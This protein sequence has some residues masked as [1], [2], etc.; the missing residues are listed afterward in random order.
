MILWGMFAVIATLMTWGADGNTMTGLFLVVLIAG[1][2]AGLMRHVYEREH[3]PTFTTIVVLIAAYCPRAWEALEQGFAFPL[4]ASADS[5]ALAMLSLICFLVVAIF[6]GKLTA[7]FFARPAAVVEHFV[8]AGRPGIGVVAM[9]ISVGISAVAGFRAGMWSHYAEIIEIESGGI[10]LELLY[11]PMLFAFSAAIG[12][13]TLKEA[14]TENSRTMRTLAMGAAWVF[15]IALLF[16][17]QSR[18]MMLGALILAI[19]SAWLESKKISLFRAGFVSA[20]LAGLGGLLLVGS[21]L[22]RQ[23]APADSAVDQLSTISNRSVDIDA[24]SKNF[25]ERLTYLWIDAT[26]IENYDALQGRFD[27]WDSMSTTLIKATP[28]LIMPDKYLY[29]KVVCELAY[30]PLGISTDLPCTPT[31]EGLIFGGILGLVITATVYGIALGIVT[32]LYRRGSFASV[33][34][35]GVALANCLLIECSAFP[36]VDSMRLLFLTAAMSGTFA[37]VLRLLN[38]VRTTNAIIQ[39]RDDRRPLRHVRHAV[40]AQK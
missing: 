18:R 36:I 6:V 11:F 35:C 31:A 28:G 24:A 25:S 26:S 16:I 20:G 15:T 13:A 1:C 39:I 22:W 12:R 32:A 40:T 21:Y 23:E 19:T 14:I 30:E 29:E 10:R 3:V 5:V 7:G 17:A 2:L 37:W 34:L 27:L 8:T 38:R 33:T 4:Y 9:G